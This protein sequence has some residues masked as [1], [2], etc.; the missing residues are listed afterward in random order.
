MTN[1]GYT[2]ILA[3][4]VK[5]PSERLGYRRDRFQ[6]GHKPGLYQKASFVRDL[7]AAEAD[8]LFSGGLSMSESFLPFS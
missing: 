1:G 3:V 8:A 7:T 2:F 6:L 5:D 4:C